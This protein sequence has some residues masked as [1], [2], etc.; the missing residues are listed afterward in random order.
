MRSA[1]DKDESPARTACD[2]EFC[3]ERTESSG[4]VRHSGRRVLSNTLSIAVGSNLA[5]VG[6]LVVL[7]L[8]A[9]QSGTAALTQFAVIVQL[10]RI[11][12]GLLDFGGSDI[13]VREVNREPSRMRRLLRILT[14][15]KLVHVVPI[16]LLFLAS[17]YILRSESAEQTSALRDAGVVGGLSLVA[18]IGVLVYRVPFR[19]GLAMHREMIA[20]IGSVAALIL[21]VY[22]LPTGSGIAA[23]L[24]AYVASRVVFGLLCMTLGFD[25]FRPS[26]GGVSL[27]DVGWAYRSLAVIGIAGVFGWLY[28]SSDLLLLQF[29]IPGGTE[30]IESAYFVAG[31][32]FAG[33]ALLALAA[34]GGTLYSVVAAA[35]HHDKPRFR[36]SCQLAVDSI[37]V[38][39]GLPFVLF[40]S[41]GPF[42][43]GLIDE[44]LGVGGARVAAPIALLCVAKAVSMTFGPALFIVNQ[45]RWILFMLIWSLAIKA[46][47][48]VAVLEFLPE[49]HALGGGS[50][51]AWVSL[52]AETLLITVPVLL[53]VR[54]F[55]GFAAS[56]WIPAR[57]AACAVA[58]VLITSVVLPEPDLAAAVAGALLYSGLV[59]A[60]RTARPVQLLAMLR[61]GDRSVPVGGERG[62]L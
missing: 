17:L 5:A 43:I 57:A 11:A 58:A 60:T 24:W 29:I 25:R 42:F 30:S 20:E 12:E 48:I 53:L 3:A 38:L 44:S 27:R 31:Q 32:K 54:R 36:R 55:T 62:R 16:G 52:A 1:P 49:D 33:P 28:V 6:R 22:F 4:P 13:F 47:A 26:L 19:A 40:F 15:H 59:L 9:R 45:Q 46:A 18:Y 41:A 10:L 14:A 61:E 35:W 56:W 34:I 51:V 7:A 2:G 21:I 50:G 37:F 23:I 39:G 8:I